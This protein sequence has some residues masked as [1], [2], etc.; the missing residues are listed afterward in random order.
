VGKG[1]DYDSLGIDAKS[2]RGRS[3][4]SDF[5]GLGGFSMYHG[6]H[7]PGFPTHPHFGFETVTV[8]REGF[9]D[10]SDSLG[11][12]ARYGKGDAQWL[13]AGKG[14]CHSEMFPLVNSDRPNPLDMFQI[15]INLPKAKKRSEPFFSMAWATE[16]PRRSFGDELGKQAHVRLVGGSFLG[17][18]GVPPPPDSWASDPRSEVVIATIKLDPGARLL[19]PRASSSQINRAIYFFSGSQLSVDSKIFSEKGFSFKLAA[20]QD[21]EVQ[22]VGKESIELLLLQG[23]PLEEP[24]VQQGPFV[25]N[26]REEL[27]QVSRDYHRT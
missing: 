13:T 25:A 27:I 20:D 17:L 12:T 16:Q 19:L 26:S 1:E 8:V 6:E 11:A 10:H 15:W 2:L 21:V 22:A 7:V 14:I 3:L 5:S 24:V 18:V 4:G 23:R 9:V